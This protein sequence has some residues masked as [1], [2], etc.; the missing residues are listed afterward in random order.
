[1]TFFNIVSSLGTNMLSFLLRF[2]HTGGGLKHGRCFLHH[3]IFPIVLSRSGHTLFFFNVRNCKNATWRKH[4]HNC[5]SAAYWKML[6]CNFI[7]TLLQSMQ[8]YRQQT[9]CG[10]EI[11]DLQNWTSA[12][13]QLSAGSWFESVGIKNYFN[14]ANSGS[15]IILDLHPILFIS[16][17]W[18]RI[19]FSQ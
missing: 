12:L 4:F 3:C 18:I 5:I 8:K 6:F 2:H 11:A 14:R 13:R 7:T 9:S 16:R 17:I 10:T 19:Y 1:M 15:E